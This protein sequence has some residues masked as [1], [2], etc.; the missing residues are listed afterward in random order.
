MRMAVSSRSVVHS[1]FLMF[2]WQVVLPTSPSLKPW[3]FA[4][5]KTLYLLPEFKQGRVVFFFFNSQALDVHSCF[6][7]IGVIENRYPLQKQK[8]KQYLLYKKRIKMVVY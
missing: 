8:N 2:V 1:L 5:L 6:R 4:F 3:D 7:N